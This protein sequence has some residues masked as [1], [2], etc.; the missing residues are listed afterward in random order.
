[1]AF[2]PGTRLGPYE[3]VFPVGAGGMGVVFRARDTKLERDV[4]IVLDLDAPAAAPDATPV[5]H[6]G[7]SA[8]SPGPVR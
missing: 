6:G 7:G 5:G 8:G 3:I 2:A 1:M 4:D